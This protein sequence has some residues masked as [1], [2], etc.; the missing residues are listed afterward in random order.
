MNGIPKEVAG[1]RVYI[2][3]NEVRDAQYEV[4]N[5]D[6]IPPNYGPP[7]IQEQGSGRRPPIVFKHG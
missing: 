3:P 1:R 5:S 4:A 2:D 6:E 7:M